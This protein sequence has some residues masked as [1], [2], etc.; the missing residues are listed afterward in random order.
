L[1][2]LNATQIFAQIALGMEYIHSKNIMHRDLKPEN[3]LFNFIGRIM[4]TDFGFSKT[5]EII[6]S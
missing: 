5:F 3:I 2:I 4:I 6:N 1:K